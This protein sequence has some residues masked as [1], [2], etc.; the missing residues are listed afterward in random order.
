M[1]ECLEGINDAKDK[2]G[3]RTAQG[4]CVVLAKVNSRYRRTTYYCAY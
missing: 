4:D 1:V 2:K 3:N